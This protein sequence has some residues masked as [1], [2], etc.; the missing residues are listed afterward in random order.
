MIRPLVH[1]TAT[2]WLN[3]PNGLVVV[4][5]RFHAY[6]QHHPDSTSWGPMHWGHAVSTDLLRWESRPIALSPDEHGTIFSG[7]AVLDSMNTAGL[8]AGSVVA[9]FT[10]HHEH[11]GER[12]GRAWSLDGGETFV[13]DDGPLLTAE[14][15]PDFRDPKVFRFVSRDGGA[16]LDHDHG[17][18][19]WVML[20]AVGR[21]VW[22]L[23]SDDLRSWTRTQVLTGHFDEGAV[24]ETP[25]LMR[26][27]DPA[28]ASVEVLTIGLGSGSPSGSSGVQ[29]MVVTFD[30]RTLR[31]EAPAFW[32]DHGTDFYA[33]QA[34]N[35]APDGDPIW[36]GWMG[37]WRVPEPFPADDWRGQ[38]SIPRR[39]TAIR[40]GG[41]LRLAQHPV[42]VDDLLGGSGVEHHVVHD[43]TARDLE[44]IRRAGALR[45]EAMTPGAV[46]LQ[47]RRG[48]DTVVVRWE[49]GD[50][51]LLATSSATP[52]V[53]PEPA[54]PVPTGEVRELRAIVDV[55][56][57]EIFC[58][59]AA[60]SFAV[61]A[62]ARPWRVR[63]VAIGT[64]VRGAVGEWTDA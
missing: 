26:V 57:V 23:I 2:G 34:W 30:G 3:D 38:L 56:S 17:D 13:K 28:G 27:H 1:L 15:E 47:L 20:V 41:E 12:Q 22:V 51:S 21:S 11:L 46:E 14:G 54:P 60:Y 33:A 35:G 43:G 48:E 39:V 50:G 31:P 59:A 6:F 10:Y 4:D 53:V 64:D 49:V 7:S 36:V 5:G 45:L 55:A 63:V 42:G 61:V 44:P 40:A 52:W 37:N 24:W 29:A 25:E 32:V 16:D 9:W 18:G 58:G 62:D 8:G 19:W